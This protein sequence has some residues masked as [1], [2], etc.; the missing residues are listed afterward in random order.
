MVFLCL[1]PVQL[2]L[3]TCVTLLDELAFKCCALSKQ[4]ELSAWKA[5]W[6]SPKCNIAWPVIG[7][8]VFLIFFVQM[9]SEFKSDCE[10]LQLVCGSQRGR[11]DSHHVRERNYKG[12][13]IFSLETHHVSEFFKACCSTYSVCT[14][15]AASNKNCNHHTQISFESTTVRKKMFTYF[16]PK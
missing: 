15:S 2:N 3:K 1:R 12:S 7:V 13:Q 9:D 14:E 6:F 8:L 16:F 4:S 5:C 11:L 10:S